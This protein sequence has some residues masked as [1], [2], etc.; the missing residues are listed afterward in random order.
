M[1]YKR[2]FVYNYSY[3]LLQRTDYADTISV[4]H[5]FFEVEEQ[6]QILKE[7]MQY[8]N[9]VRRYRKDMQLA[10]AV[11]RAIDDCIR[12]EILRD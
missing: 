1:N 2:L 3:N 11:D 5:I 4:K 8:V 12:E 6:C 10:E 9:R 7:Y